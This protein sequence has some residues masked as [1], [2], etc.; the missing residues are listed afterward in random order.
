MRKLSPS[1]VISLIALFVALSG[2]AVAAKGLI[3]SAGI[4]DGTIQGIDVKNKSLTPADFSGSVRGPQGAPGPQGPQGVPGTPGAK[5]DKGDACPSS[6]AACRGPKGPTGEQGIQ[7]IQ[8]PRGFDA[9]TRV[10]VNFTTLQ[11]NFASQTVT[12]PGAHPRV[13]GGGVNTT[14]FEDFGVV[15]ESYPDGTN[16]WTVR[17]RNNGNNFALSSTAYAICVD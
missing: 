15:E 7:G 11:G 9:I 13:I 3:T 14:S 4:K 12:C 1:M 10:S 2:T 16:A 8:G 6:D 17:M 5:G